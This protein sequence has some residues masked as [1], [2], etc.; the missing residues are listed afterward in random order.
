MS[1]FPLNAISGATV[2]NPAMD[3]DSAGLAQVF[4]QGWTDADFA[5]PLYGQQ[6]A[7]ISSGFSCGSLTSGSLTPQSSTSASTSRRH[8]LVSSASKVLPLLPSSATRPKQLA[9]QRT[10]VAYDAL[11]EGF[12]APIGYICSSP[13]SQP[14]EISYPI[15][16]EEPSAPGKLQMPLALGQPNGIDG[17]PY[18]MHNQGDLFAPQSSFE[19]EDSIAPALRFLSPYS[20]YERDQRPYHAHPGMNRT[21][22]QTHLEAPQTVAPAQTTYTAPR[23]PSPTLAEPFVSPIRHSLVRSPI[24]EGADFIGPLDNFACLDNALASPTSLKSYGSE[25]SHTLLRPKFEENDEQPIISDSVPSQTFA[26]F[27]D[28]KSPPKSRLC[29]RNQLGK[30]SP[31]YTIRKAQRHMQGPIR[32]E[33]GPQ[34]IC[35]YCKERKAFKRPEHLNRHVKSIHM[36]GKYE[37]CLVVECN[38]RI[39][40]NRPDNMK[41][42]LRKTHLYSGDGPKKGKKNHWLSIEEAKQ[43][44]FGD[45]DPRTNPPKGKSIKKED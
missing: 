29:R 14:M 15:E 16:F 6:D 12:G 41:Q 34:N 37:P 25:Q 39:C 23:T 42:H 5:N 26:T 21:R 27:E 35:P 20:Q 31:G 30:R 32:Y 44:G 2:D 4:D 38:R 3:V 19:S 40:R 43:R 11:C 33:P 22:A 45:I 7:S 36:P 18:S 1:S 10:P 13:G 28:E 24:E 9:A 17:E 8:S